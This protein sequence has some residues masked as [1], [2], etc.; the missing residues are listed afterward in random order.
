MA[1]NGLEALSLGDFE[2]NPSKIQGLMSLKCTQLAGAS[3]TCAQN[4]TLGYLVEVSLQTK[5]ALEFLAETNVDVAGIFM[6]G[7]N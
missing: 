5:F 6:A 4:E 3:K 1:R 7:L 2:T